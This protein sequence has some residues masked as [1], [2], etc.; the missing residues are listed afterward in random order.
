MILML[1]VIPMILMI[2]VKSM[3]YT[4]GSEDTGDTVDTGDDKL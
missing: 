1:S 2:L 3:V 4:D